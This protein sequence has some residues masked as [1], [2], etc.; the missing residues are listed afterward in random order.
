MKINVVDRNNNYL[1]TVICKECGLVWSDP[2]PAKVKEYYKKYYRLQYKGT[3]KPKMKHIYRA[4]KVAKSRIEKIG[5]YLNHNDKILGIGSGGGEFLYLLKYNGYDVSGIEPNEDYA[6]YSVDK[7]NLNIHIGFIQDILLEKETYNVITMWHVLEHTENPFEILL[8]LNSCLKNNGILIVEAPNVESVSLAP[9]HRFHLAHLYNFNHNTLKSIGEKAG[10]L[11]KESSISE[12]GGNI[13]TVFNKSNS[14]NY[15]SDW[16]VEGNYQN[17]YN[18]IKNHTSAHYYLSVNTYQRL[19]KK[20]RGII[21][22][23]LSIKG[24]K[25]GKNILDAHFVK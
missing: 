9:I 20:I 21:D 24:F 10:F 17:I 16:R 25:K 2:R 4:G 6:K 8:R 22:E 12:D 1:R 3:I 13:L 19:F 5:K 23:K 14:G 11:L 15:I 7:Y 18:I